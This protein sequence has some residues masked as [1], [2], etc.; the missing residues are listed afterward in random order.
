MGKVCAQMTLHTLSLPFA[1]ASADSLAFFLLF[2]VKHSTQG[3]C[4]LTTR[5]EGLIAHVSPAMRLVRVSP[6]TSQ[7]DKSHHGP[8]SCYT[9]L[10]CPLVRMF[11]REWRP[12]L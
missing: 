9:L 5:L 2:R 6:V 4:T 1:R 3:I 10:V 7:Q 11:L 8:T 12:V